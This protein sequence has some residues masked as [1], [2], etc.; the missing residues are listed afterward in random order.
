MDSLQKKEGKDFIEM[1]TTKE[2][3][4]YMQIK[5]LS[6]CK[7]MYTLTRYGSMPFILYPKKYEDFLK[8]RKV[9]A[10][11]R[12]TLAYS[13]HEISLMI[14]KAY[15][16]AYTS[17]KALIAIVN[18]DSFNFHLELA[19]EKLGEEFFKELVGDIKN[20]I[21]KY[22]IKVYLLDEKFPM[23]IFINEDTAY[24]SIIHEGTTHG[25]AITSKKVRDIY[26]NMYDEMVKRSQ[27][28]ES[29]LREIKA[30]S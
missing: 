5:M 27:T 14:N 30:C 21:K 23:Q 12:P 29:Y 25:T 18:K 9:V 20:R 10:G 1:L 28:I 6:A 2:E 11:A 22:N 26:V 13:S 17:G 4:I 19:K 7:K 15:M 8:F 16:D 3:F 24:L